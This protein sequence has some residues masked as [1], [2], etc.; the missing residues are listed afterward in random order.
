MKTKILYSIILML[1]FSVVVPQ[2]KEVLYKF[3]TI[4][5]KY[6]KQECRWA[7]KCTKNCIDLSLKEIK[8]RKGIPCKVC[9]PPKY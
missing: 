5:K 6:H 2:Q 9:K 4:N 8:E 1:F 3:N 7:V